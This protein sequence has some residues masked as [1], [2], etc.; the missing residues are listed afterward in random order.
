MICDVYVKWVRHN[1]PA[2]I[3]F[4]CLKPQAMLLFSAEAVL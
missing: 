4:W 3:G 2:G 1:T